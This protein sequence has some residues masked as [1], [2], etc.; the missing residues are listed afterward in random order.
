M[1]FDELMKYYVEDIPSQIEETPNMKQRGR[2]STRNRRLV[3]S[4]KA[5][6][7]GFPDDSIDARIIQF[8]D[9]NPATTEEV[10]H[11]L[12]A[13]WDDYAAHS[14]CKEKI[15]Q[16]VIDNV[17]SF[18]SEDEK[19]FDDEE[20]EIPALDPYGNEDENP[21]DLHRYVGGALDDYERSSLN[22]FE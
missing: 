12:R 22:D 14:A 7:I 2:P 6:E 5:F 15:R 3:P 13:N 4:A 18:E 1:K 10:C 17:L 19:G 9:N 20:D 21:V 11:F 16:M 8:V